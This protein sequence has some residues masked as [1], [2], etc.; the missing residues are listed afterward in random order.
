[1]GTLFRFVVASCLLALVT[2]AP[3]CQSAEAPECTGLNIYGEEG[4]S[5]KPIAGE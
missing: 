3:L 1:M 4:V 5:D 2:Q